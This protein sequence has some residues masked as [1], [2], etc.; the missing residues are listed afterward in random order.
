[1]KPLPVPA[2]ASTEPAGASLILGVKA[3]TLGQPLLGLLTLL[4]DA[5][6][7]LTV[8]VAVEV[9][10]IAGELVP[11]VDVTT[12]SAILAWTSMGALCA[13]AAAEAA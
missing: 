10:V 13:K 12:L 1:M 8:L 3:I 5:I 11:A 2:D 6:G 4:E 9:V 7:T